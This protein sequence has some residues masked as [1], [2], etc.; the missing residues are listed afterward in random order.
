MG[1]TQHAHGVDTVKA[2][3]NL[4]LARGLPARPGSGLVPIRGHSGVQG[5]AEVGCVPGVAADDARPLGRRCGASRCPSTPGWTATEAIAASAAGDVDTFWLVGGNLLETLPDTGAKRARALARPRLRIHQDIVL[6]SSMLVE[7]AGDV[8]LLPATTRY[9]SPGGGTETSTER[10]IIFSPEIP[11]RRIGSAKPE[12]W[13]FREVMRARVPGAR[14]PGRARR[15]PRRSAARSI[16]RC[17]STPASTALA[18]QGDSV[19]WGGRAPLRRRPLRDAD[20]RAHFAPV[21]LREPRRCRPI[22]SS[23]RRGAASSSTRWCSAPSIR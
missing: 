14:A 12:W 23:S 11:G 13:V 16:A 15:T 3:V 6:S 10:R 4:G 1:L 8:L 22:A 7:G 2:L 9:E 19:Q 18:R 21:A 5:G 20:G 17:R